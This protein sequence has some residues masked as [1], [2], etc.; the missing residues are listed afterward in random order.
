MAAVFWTLLA[1]TKLDKETAHIAKENPYAARRVRE[2]IVQTGESLAEFP[3]RGRHGYVENTREIIVQRTRY[4]LA[5]RVVS[6]SVQILDII[7]TSLDTPGDVL[8]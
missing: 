1:Q 3:H 7:H 8:H 5:Y 2:A 4:F 6:G